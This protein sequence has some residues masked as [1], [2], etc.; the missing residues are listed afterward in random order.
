MTVISAIAVWGTAYDMGAICSVRHKQRSPCSCKPY[1]GNMAI[2]RAGPGCSCQRAGSERKKSHGSSEAK[3]QLVTGTT[4]IAHADAVQPGS[5]LHVRVNRAYAEMPGLTPEQII[6]PNR[7]PR[8]S[9][10]LFALVRGYIRK[11]CAG[12]VGRGHE[13]GSALRRTVGPH[14]LQGA[15]RPDLDGR[16]GKCSR[17]G[18]PLARGHHRTQAG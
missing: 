7:S 2:T 12:R 4:P 1:I 10:E 14:W 8:S 11:S 18:W 6:G 16:L 13:E 15:Y 17:A 3:L 9:V 5:A